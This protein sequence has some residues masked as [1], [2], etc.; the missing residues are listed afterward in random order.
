[1]VKPSKTEDEP[2]DPGLGKDGAVVASVAVG[3]ET[4]GVAL[5]V[6][7]VAPLSPL[8]TRVMFTDEI[9]D[10]PGLIVRA[11]GGAVTKRAV[12]LEKNPVSKVTGIGV[13][14]TEFTMVTHVV[15]SDALVAVQPFG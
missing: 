14:V 2:V 15:P 3:P 6:P 5:A 1:M 12:T 11:A 4:E 7:A 13:A 10:V 8:N 9:P